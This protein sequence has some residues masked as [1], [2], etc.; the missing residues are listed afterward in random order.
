MGT[1]KNTDRLEWWREARFGMF[2]HWGLYAVPAGIWKGNDIPGIGEWIMS[3]ARISVPEYEKLANEFNPVNFNA[4][5]WVKVAKDAGMKYLIITSKHHDGFAMFNSAC[6]DYDI[7]DATPWGKDPLKAL[8]KECA[9]AGIRLGFYYSQSQDW[10]DPDAFGNGW[11]YADEKKKDF[12]KYLRRKCI[13]Q[14][15]ELLT[16]YGPISII[17][18]DTPCRITEQQSLRLKR[19]VHKLQPDCLVS[20]R[21]GNERGDYGS[22]GDN[23]RPPGAITGDWETPCTLNDTWAF[24]TRDKNWKSVETLLELLVSCAGKGINYLL[25]VGPTAEGIIPRVSVNRLKAIGD[26]LKINGEAIYESQASP[27]PYEHDWGRITCRKGKLYLLFLKW[28]RGTFALQG[29]RN[30]VKGARILG[31]QDAEIAVTQSHSHKNDEHVIELTLPRK[32]PGTYVAVVALD[33]VGTPDAD[34]MPLQQ[35]DGV[36]TLPVHMARIR[37]PKTTS[38][39]RH[40]GIEG[41]KTTTTSLGWEF[42]LRQAGT[43]RVMVQSAINGELKGEF[44]THEVA[45]NV[46]RQSTQGKAGRKDLP[47]EVKHDDWCTTESDIGTITI[48]KPGWCKLSL[49]AIRLDKKAKAGLTAVGVRLVPLPARQR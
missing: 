38:I 5:A 12:D 21:I 39:G 28:P 34:Q 1:K 15:T 17:W 6:S 36:V 19:H 13:P 8:A 27:F 18:F 40:G 37:G 2:I 43:F 24:K 20:G 31:N 11:D 25:N 30:R 7:V 23:Q 3:R 16:E 44:G 14:L 9:K 49:K 33:I 4:R 46:G 22:L 41:W 29:L 48:A 47:R 42:N 35:L 10:H 26:W 32:K 45:V